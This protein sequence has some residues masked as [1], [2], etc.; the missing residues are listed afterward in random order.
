MCVGGIVYDLIYA[1]IMYMNLRYYTPPAFE[2]EEKQIYFSIHYIHLQSLRVIGSWVFMYKSIFLLTGC[3]LFIF[4][5]AIASVYL[6]KVIL[7]FPNA[8]S[9]ENFRQE[10]ASNYESSL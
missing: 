6:S 9:P 10:L 7:L 5:Q 3:L 2:T 1:H 8:K 4:L